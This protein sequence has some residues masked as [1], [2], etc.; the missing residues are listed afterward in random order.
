MQESQYSF[1]VGD[2]PDIYYYPGEGSSSNLIAPRNKSSGWPGGGNGI[3]SE[4]EPD[5]R[6][7][8]QP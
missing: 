8:Q 7:D 4:P 1:L 2:G 3:D 5:N 6:I